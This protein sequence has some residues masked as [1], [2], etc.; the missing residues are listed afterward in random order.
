MNGE[1]G[2]MS[3][4]TNLPE[5]GGRPVGVEGALPLVGATIT[6]VAAGGV[7]E[8]VLEQRFRNPHPTPLAVSYRFPLPADAAVSG[9]SFTIGARPIVGEVEGRAAARERF[10]RA[11]VEGKTAALLDQDRA[12]LFEQEIGNIPPGA[13][14][15]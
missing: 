9:Y 14:V 1:E 15:V 12:S 4:T 7:A 10:E 5:V 13:E 6:A 2:H 8:V 11:L 3:T